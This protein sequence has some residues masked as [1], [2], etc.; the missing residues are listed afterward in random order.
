MRAIARLI[1]CTALHASAPTWAIDGPPPPPPVDLSTWIGVDIPSMY[2]DQWPDG[3]NPEFAAWRVPT[4][5]RPYQVKSMTLDV[6]RTHSWDQPPITVGYWSFTDVSMGLWI[7]DDGQIHA[8]A[9]YE[10]EDE[11]GQLIDETFVSMLRVPPGTSAEAVFDSLA[12][13]SVPT[14][15]AAWRAIP[16]IPEPAGAPLVLAGALACT[17]ARRRSLQ[18]AQASPAVIVPPAGP[19]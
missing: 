14:D 12:N 17:W 19:T 18:G 5:G 15:L 10:H 8:F 6:F 2:G 16:T 4:D 13:Q 9:T 3:F 1:V 11:T 7:G